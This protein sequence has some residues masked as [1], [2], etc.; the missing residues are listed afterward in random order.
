VFSFCG[1]KLNKHVVDFDLE[2]IGVTLEES[3]E[4]ISD[5]LPNERVD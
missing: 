4:I 5:D 2:D 3:R 1:K